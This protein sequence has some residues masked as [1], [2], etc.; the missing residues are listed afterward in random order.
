[1][2]LIEGETLAARVRRDG[3]L[4]AKEALKIAIQIARAL[5]GGCGPRFNPSRSEAEQYHADE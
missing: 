2:E 1:M 5:I 3:P 4:N